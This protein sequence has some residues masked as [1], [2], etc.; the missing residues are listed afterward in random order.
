VTAKE[1]FGISIID[2]LKS[3]GFEAYFAGGCVRDRV[4]GLPAK[5]YDIATSAP[6]REIQ[7]LFRRTIPVG[8]QFGVIIVIEEEVNFEVATFRTEGGYQDGRR[9]SKV[10]FTNVE[11]DARRR[12]FTVNGLYL[13]PSTG[14]ILD[15]VG[16]QK[17][18]ASKIIRTIGKAEERFEE[19]HLRM[20]RAVRFACQLDFEI[21]DATFTAVK[22]LAGL[23]SKVSH[24]RVRDELVKILTSE[25]PGRGMRLLDSSGL[26]PHI[27]PEI[28][29][30]KGV[31]QP[32]EYH[33]EGDVFVHTLMLI[34]GLKSAPIE[35]AMGALLHDVAK[36]ATFVRAPDRI[37]F[38]GHDKLGAE[39]ARE[40]CKR[41][42]FPNQQTDVICALVAE[43]LRFKD[44][45]Q[46]RVSTLKRF[47]R[48]EHFDLHMQLHLLDCTASHKI[49]TAYEFCKNKLAELALEPPPPSRILTGQDLIQLGFK[50]GKQ[51]SEILRSVED[52]VLEGQIKTKEDAVDFVSK[53]F[54]PGSTE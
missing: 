3:A 30:M 43:H 37:R 14:D 31:E 16:G 9:P 32:S 46:M 44:V 2:R 39:M 12:D 6:P 48:M 36:P 1:Q 45:F 5:D 4:R 20:L 50:P 19:D 38:N 21:E 18:I 34:D 29:T 52:G 11:E 54:K 51:F 40:I 24:E 35:L 33:P 22:K 13:D 42:A 10:E 47:L 15:F 26:L 8:A 28:E 7:R 49:L 17:D 53:T 23:I 41:L 27:L 25:T